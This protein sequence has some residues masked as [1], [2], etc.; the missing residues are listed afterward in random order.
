M[1][2]YTQDH[3]DTFPKSAAAYKDAVFPYLQSEQYFTVRPTQGG[4]VDYA[5]TRSCKESA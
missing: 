2:Q 1:I 3:N 4:P 5:M